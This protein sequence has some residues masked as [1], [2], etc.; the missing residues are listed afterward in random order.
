MT[1]HL[2][3]ITLSSCGLISHN[4]IIS[5]N[6]DFIL[7]LWI[8]IPQV[9]FYISQLQIYIPHL[10]LNLTTMN[11]YL[12]IVTSYLTTWLSHFK[13]ITITFLFFL[14]WGRNRLPQYPFHEEKQVNLLIKS[15][16]FSHR[17]WTNEVSNHW[18]NILDFVCKARKH[19]K[20]HY[21]L[22]YT[23]SFTNHF[24]RHEWFAVDVLLCLQIYALWLW[25]LTA[26]YI[27]KCTVQC[28]HCDDMISSKSWC[29]CGCW[30]F[31]CQ[32]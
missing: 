30:G 26:Q 28:V 22:F 21:Q 27:H 10:T 19:F 25:M 6:Y 23:R 29:L 4:V 1:S 13:P 32:E 16:G 24:R 20:P 18:Q 31:F 15:L 9:G 12:T 5:P 14:L 7:Q 8:Y 11:L 17:L 2:I 3:I